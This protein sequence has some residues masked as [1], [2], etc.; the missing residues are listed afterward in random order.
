LLAFPVK[1]LLP[2]GWEYDL[3]SVVKFLRYS[4]KFYLPL[5]S[6]ALINLTIIDKFGT[7]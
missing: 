5:P 4:F 6:K 7:R 1:S 3:K 2:A